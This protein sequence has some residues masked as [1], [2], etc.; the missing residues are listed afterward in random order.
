MLGIIDLMGETEHTPTDPYR[1]LA[2]VGVFLIM[3]SPTVL[4]V[5]HGT[6]ADGRDASVF[7]LKNEHGMTAEVSELGATLISLIVP[8]RDGKLA[9]VTLGFDD[10]SGW[11]LN[12]AC[13][14]ST[15]GRF[16]NRIR[17]GKFQIDGQT[18]QLETNE[19]RGDSAHHLHG[20]L[21]G[22]D[23]CLWRGKQTQPS[24]VVMS[25]R[26]PAGEEGYPGNVDVSVTFR[27]TEDN[28]F[29]WSAEATSDAATPINLVH[30]TY[31]NLS[32]DPSS[33]ILDHQLM[34][35]AD[36][37]LP[38]DDSLIPTG[39][40]APVAG[41]PMDFT[42]SEQ[43]GKRIHADF[44]PLA[45]ARGYDHCWVLREAGNTRLVAK[46]H[47]PKSG[48]V[49]ELLTNQ[50]GVQVYC[51]NFLSSEIIGKQAAPMQ[52]YAG[53]CLETE[54]FPD[55]P[56]QPDFPDSILRPG[57][58]YRHVMIHRFSTAL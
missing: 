4:C 34:L 57:E 24:E 56:N 6:L 8:D 14:G 42:S 22:F 18:F 45:R 19:K 39:E 37:F 50:P 7:T 17:H 55:A 2:E 26:S 27:L 3:K 54:Q 51:G 49:M 47:D 9:D 58:T 40:R 1:C 15:V 36:A 5:L 31:W 29:V 48:R 13:F 33:D 44:L 30:H 35:E 11:E 25:R 10:F 12:P 38:T 16:G 21:R 28:E 23:Q 46:L 20:G 43:I 52:P 41:T 32:G 53:V